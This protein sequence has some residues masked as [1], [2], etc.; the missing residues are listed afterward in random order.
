MAIKNITGKEGLVTTII[1]LIIIGALLYLVHKDMNNGASLTD[2]LTT[3][4]GWLTTAIMFLFG[5]D[6]YLKIKK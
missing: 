5:K 4:S 3:V 1:A 2:A 6:E